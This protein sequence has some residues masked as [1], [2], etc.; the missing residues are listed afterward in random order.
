MNYTHDFLMYEI[1]T[2]PAGN[3][4]TFGPLFKID[5]TKFMTSKKLKTENLK[6]SL[7][8]R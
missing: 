3:F 1:V 8:S 4:G 7:C 2:T 5:L 6:H